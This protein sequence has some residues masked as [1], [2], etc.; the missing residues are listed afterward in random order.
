M[1][2]FVQSSILVRSQLSISDIMNVQEKFQSR[3][4]VQ[5]LWVGLLFFLALFSEMCV[6]EMTAQCVRDKMDLEPSKEIIFSLILCRTINDVT[7]KA[8]YSRYMFDCR[9]T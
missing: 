9:E 6:L 8:L 7:K 1:L 5:L 4:K 2:V 3:R